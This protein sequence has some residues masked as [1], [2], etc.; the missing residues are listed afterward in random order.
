MKKILLLLTVFTCGIVMG[1]DPVTILTTNTT[2]SGDVSLNGKVVVDAGVT[3]T[4][5]PGTV[6]KSAFKSDPVDAVALIVAKDG[7]LIANGTA[8]LPII[9]TAESDPLTAADV[10]AGT[11]V[12]A[13]NLDLGGLWGGIILLGNNVTGS[14]TTGTDNI[15]GIAS[16]QTWTEYGGTAT[17]D[18]SG[19]LKYISIR[20][21]GATIANGDEING[22]TLGGVGNGTI[23]E[24]IEIISNT[25]D[26][27]E[28]F[29]GNVN[30][31]NL[32]VY[33]QT[34]DAI[35]IDQAYSGTITNA[36]VAMGAVSD[37]VFEIDGTES[38][39]T[40][41]VTG[42][43]TINGVTAVGIGSSQ[44][45]TDQYGH[46]KS[47][48]TGN[49]MNIVYKDF[50]SGTT[51]EGLD[52]DTFGSSLTFSNV[53]FITTDN[54]ATINMAS[55]SPSGAFTSAE[56]EILSEQV[57]GTG[58]N[59]CSFSE[60]TA[61][62]TIDSNL[63]SSTV[64]GDG[65]VTILTS[66]TTWSGDIALDGKVVV[67]AN[68][69]L[70]IQPGTVI[71]AAFKSDPVDASALIIAKDGNIIANG[72]EPL[73]IV[74]TTEF[75]ALTAADVAGGVY[76]ADGQ[77]LELGGLWGGVIILGNNVTGSGTTGTDN[78]EGIASGQTW[79]EYGGTATNDS[80]GSL[81]Y[82]SIR[83]GGA[84]IANGDEINGLTLGGVGNG[85]SISNIEIVSN[86]DD[87]IEFFGGNVDV[88]RILIYNQTDDAIDIDQAYSGTITN[89][90]VAMG[91]VSD[92]V[93]EIDGTESTATPVVTGSYTI[94][95]VTA[96]GIGSSQ[97][98]IDQYGHWKSDATGNNMNIVYKDFQPGTTIEGLDLDTF[99]S[100]LTFSNLD[101][102]TTDDLATIN[103]ASDTPSAAFTS[104]QAEIISEQLSGSGSTE[105][106]FYSWTA[107]FYSETGTLGLED[108]L[109]L[110]RIAIYPNPALNNINVR[111]QSPIESLKLYNISGQLILENRNSN[112]INVSE[113]TNGI[114][115][116]E[117]VS[118]STKM[119]ERIIKK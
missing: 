11:Y 2:W 43:Y 59:T 91:A 52:L 56:A 107:Y 90:Y 50:Q 70:T 104:A 114:Y 72:T 106:H 28:F 57:V 74:F 88:D 17:D 18:S 103:M 102:V 25:D 6:V 87:G 36:Y 94:N 83:H 60:W 20:H 37:N 12:S 96:I 98:Q 26:G 110:D 113:L 42:S 80:S 118:G 79:T 7:T 10:A 109:E 64:V 49:N 61:Y 92:N 41:T 58:A 8:A 71:K 84:T 97:T 67:E 108:E 75:D 76:V 34:D 93:F 46:W 44:T 95:G 51:I 116:L 119:I 55:D 38:T 69:T 53:D 112:T 31:N 82:I 105:T 115:L 47:D 45:Q 63:C 16:G 40:P 15:E 73:P 13:F 23:I 3:L 62:A 48:A 86:T 30:V 100:S 27:I 14:G 81:D 77:N 89:A 65:T 19:S 29:G 99:G 5:E 35:D 117:V 33:N 66:D 1:Q 24:N 21:G 32:L 101:F 68:T 54:F 78:I 9:F 85:T 4:I 111:S 22:L 39:A